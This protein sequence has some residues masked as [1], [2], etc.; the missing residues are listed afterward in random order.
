M[1]SL[2]LF[3]CAPYVRNRN[4]HNYF[5]LVPIF[6]NRN[7]CNSCK[8]SGFYNGYCKMMVF[9]VLTLCNKLFQC[10]TETCQLHLQDDWILFKTAELTGRK[11]CL[12]FVRRSQGWWTVRPAN[13]SFTEL[14]ENLSSL[15][16]SY[17]I[18]HKLG[19]FP[20]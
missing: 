17:L 9:W 3:W 14:T 7:T 1:F 10:F 18:G 13:R 8:F 16:F 6:Q 4:Y 20:V 12:S 19:S 2:S 15:L 5:I 11:K